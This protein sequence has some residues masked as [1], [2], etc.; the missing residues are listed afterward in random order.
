MYWAKALS[1][2]TNDG[3]LKKIF[4]KIYSELSKE[5]NTIVAELNGVQGSPQ[6]IKGYYFADV[7]L[8]EKAMRPSKTLNNILSTFF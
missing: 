4:T 7:V 8:A 6:D 3:E 1:E 2:Q 5:E